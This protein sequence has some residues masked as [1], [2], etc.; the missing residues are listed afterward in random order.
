MGA[1]PKTSACDTKGRVRGAK[2][3]WVADGSVLPEATG[4]NPMLT[5]LAASR[6]IA[7][8]IAIDLGVAQPSDTAAI[9]VSHL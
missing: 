9:P 3:L 7:R 1:N 5:I 2:N 6:G 4:V 8:N